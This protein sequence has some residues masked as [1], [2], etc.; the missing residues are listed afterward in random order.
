MMSEQHISPRQF[1]RARRPE[2]FSDSVGNDLPVLDR[3]QLEYHLSTLTSRSEELAFESFARRLLERT[4]CPNL[5][6]HTGPTGGGDSKVD[7]ETYPVAESLAMA[8]FVGDGA[9]AATERWAFAFSAKAQWKPKLESD[10]TKIVATQRGYT[11]AFF[12]SNQFISDRARSAAEDSLRKKHGI[13]VRIFDRTWILDKVFT[14]HLEQLVIEELKLT[15]AV[16]HEIRKG[17]LDTQHEQDLRA[18]EGRIEI[19][20]QAKRYTSILVEDCLEAA[21][22]ARNLERPRAEIDGLYMRTTR[23][24]KQYGTSHQAL[25]SIY[26]QAWTSFWWYEDYRQFIELYD[27]VAK[28]AAGSENVY[29]L[30][31]WNNLHTL[32]YIA[33]RE[34]GIN[35]QTIELDRCTAT[36]VH[37]LHRLTRDQE[38][39]STALQART[40]R[41]TLKLVQE[42]HK[43]RQTAIDRVLRELTT[44]VR[45]SAYLI[46]YPLEPLVRI[47]TELG[48][49]LGE[50]QTYESLFEA[51]VQISA[52][53]EGE[54]TAGRM[55]LKRGAQQMDAQHWYDGIRT[56]GRALGKLYKHESRSEEV[57]ALYLCARAYERIGLLW[58]ARGTMLAAASIATNEIWKYERVTSIQAACYKRLKWM[59]LQL[60]RIPHMLAWHQLD[61]A[62]REILVEK[63]YDEEELFEDEIPFDAVT[64]IL[65]LHSDIPVLRQL[66]A[67]P[68]TLDEVGLPLSSIALRYALGYED[69]LPA[70]LLG[71]PEELEPPIIMFRRWRDQPAADDLPPTPVLYI[72]PEITLTS[73]ILG[74]E[75]SVLVTNQSPCIELAESLLAALESLLATGAAE[76]AAACEPRLTI[77]IRRSDFAPTPFAFHADYQDGLPH[78]EIGCLS[79]SPHQLS[80][81]EQAAI[82]KALFDVVVAVAARV[83][84]IKEPEQFFT[85]LFRDDLAA[86]RAL[87]FTTSFVVV[88]NVLGYNP[89]NTLISWTK[90]KPD[91]A[92]RRTEVWD[93]G[94]RQAQLAAVEPYTP[95]F[96]DPFEE[97][98]PA[99]QAPSGASHRHMATL[100]V[101]REE[102]WD[103]AGWMGTGFE[104]GHRDGMPPILGLLFRNGAAAARIFALWRAEL[105]EQDD[106]NK[107]RV[108]IIRG[109][110][111]ANPSWYRVVIGSNITGQMAKRGVTN[112]VSISKSC[113][114][115]TPSDTHLKRF[116]A[117]Y[118]SHGSYLLSYGFPYNEHMIRT[119][120]HQLLK[121]QLIVRHAWEIGRHD[122]DS[123]G[124]REE[125]DPIIP[126]GRTDAPILTLLNWRQSRQ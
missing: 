71:A 104:P 115:T 121:Q 1:M 99:L 18:I 48:D 25:K 66:V 33:V 113:T 74:C 107:L 90:N 64:G 31:L 30:E 102:L 15:T 123:A 47:L 32:L 40:L 19:A 39:P 4:V 51:V 35:V 69:G 16:R 120:E 28:L 117:S 59:E 110:S 87:D 112:F 67:L 24:A 17:P 80:L 56:L 103:Q 84:L 21:D 85:K 86:Q 54:M 116:L 49:V 65:F 57:R 70:E 2:R 126:E 83:F 23:M 46:G 76:G 37:E 72:E 93:A 68:D 45:D 29:E 109:I 125:D 11:K 75:I 100:S 7:A 60:G 111:K 52:E 79:F 122:L 106:D 58:A 61:R 124:V 38:R 14:N 20:L 12:V 6:P 118:R 92:L 73:S 34:G 27:E 43:G 10:I 81:D 105:G 62:I 114:L 88:G 41:L 98:S 91:Y 119:G 97:S 96:A 26:E 50:R 42:L 3:S 8:W 89:K 95:R 53:R 63:G 108:S 13:D 77:T 78:V 55:L 82:R 44:I 9:E 94:D 36:L 22:L 5:L 101:I